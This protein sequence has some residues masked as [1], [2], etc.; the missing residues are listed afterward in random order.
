[1]P[2]ISSDRARAA[3][4]RRF[5][6]LF[7]FTPFLS[8]LVGVGCRSVDPAFYDSEDRPLEE[9]P[10]ALYSVAI[11]PLELSG[12]NLDNSGDGKFRYPLAPE[13]LQQQLVADLER[14]GAASAVYP[15][16]TS[17]LVEAVSLRSDLLVRPRLRRAAQFERVGTSKRGFTSGLFWFTT[18]IGSFWVQDTTYDA[19]LAVDFDIVNPHDTQRIDSFTASSEMADLTFWD[20]NDF[21]SLGTLQSIVLPP[22]WT[23]ANGERTNTRLSELANARLAGRLTRYLK[24]ELSS[25]E[26]DFLGEVRLESPVNG[27]Q[28]GAVAP[29]KGK[30]IAPQQIT[31]IAVYLN[32]ELTPAYELTGGA[33]PPIADQRL[34]NVYQVFFDERI[35]L[36]P[37]KNLIAI[38]LGIAGRL[39]SRTL[40]VYNGAETDV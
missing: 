11:A 32:D 38:E 22:F 39:T 12:A 4:R 21:L 18:W 10:P 33:L 36:D 28:V 17:D 14:L 23:S 34:G 6:P 19:G 13:E 3:G 5:A 8:V 15:V 26:R 35:P 27:A 25:T 7:L 24:E 1:M 31:E 30:V 20:R 2:R 29:L 40:V 9:L 37:G 16:G